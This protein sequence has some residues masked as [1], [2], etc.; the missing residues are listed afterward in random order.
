MVAPRLCRL[1]DG[2]LHAPASVLSP[3]SEAQNWNRQRSVEFPCNQNNGIGPFRLHS[4]NALLNVSDRF[5]LE[6]AVH[7]FLHDDAVDLLAF[8]R[9]RANDRKAVRCDLLRI[10]F[11]FNQRA[12]SGERESPMCIHGSGDRDATYESAWWIV[13]SG[14]IKKSAPIVARLLAETSIISPTASQSRRSMRVT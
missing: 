14:Q 5:R 12:R 1:R 2:A 7:K 3:E 10:E 8:S 13:L 6:R 9:I 11:A 4:H